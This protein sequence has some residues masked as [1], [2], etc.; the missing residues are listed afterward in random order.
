MPSV[1]R[2]RAE[3]LAALLAALAAVAL[4]RWQPVPSSNELIYLMI[5]WRRAHPGVMPLDWTFGGGRPDHVAYDLVITPL[6]RFASLEAVGRGLRVI[7]WLFV[8]TGFLRLGSRLGVRPFFGAL[9]LGFW[10][11]AGQGLYAN[12]WLFSTV[13]AKVFAYGLVFF[14]LERVAAGRLNAGA[15]L[16]GLSAVLHAA[17]G[18]SVGLAS[19]LALP[20]A[21][22]SRREAV[23]A[24][25]RLAVGGLLGGLL[26]LPTL[27]GSSAVPADMWEVMTRFVMPMHFDVSTFRTDLIA[28]TFAQLVA[29]L[30]VWRA[31]PADRPTR[32]LAVFLGV[33]GAVTLG[34]LAAYAAGWYDLLRFYPFRVFPMLGPLLFLLVL[35][36]AFQRGLLA[37]SRPWL[38]VVLAAVLLW[39]GQLVPDPRDE[40]RL[41]EVGRARGPDAVARV[42][43]WS[44]AH[45]PDSAVVIAP[46]FRKDAFYLTQRAQI[47]NLD[48][49]ASDRLAEW[50]ERMESLLG[51]LAGQ[52][53]RNI[54]RSDSAYAGLSEAAVLG[55]RRR[56][57]GDFLISRGA[58]AFPVLHRDGGWAVYDLRGAA[59]PP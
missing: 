16:L 41:A 48:A 32:F 1:T 25:A 17:V 10:L 59:P 26:I 43:L 42:M 14:G 21:A 46:P 34:G 30:L 27:L 35:G 38:T 39:Y 22:A 58:Y 44:R 53:G 31:D 55:V 23:H 50:R 24:L 33:L 3:F 5:P 56:F 37:P 40:W 51:P 15:L 29:V 19:A 52:Q 45:L 9:A 7:A 28:L 11:L 4:F 57:G 2:T 47:A 18:S 36:G 49:P 13:E 6:M 12:E 20:A 54:A 8:L